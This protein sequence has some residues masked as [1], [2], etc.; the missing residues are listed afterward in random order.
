MAVTVDETA[1]WFQVRRGTG[2]ELVVVRT[3]TADDY[4]VHPEVLAGCVG[5]YC[6]FRPVAVVAAS[7]L[8]A[9]HLCVVVHSVAV[10]RRGGCVFGG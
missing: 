9:I 2:S 10:K 5:C 4:V 1:R 6:P 7:I 3:P 8:E